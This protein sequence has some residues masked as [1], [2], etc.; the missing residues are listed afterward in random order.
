[1]MVVMELR[2]NTRSG[3]MERSTG[4]HFLAYGHTLG[5]MH[6]KRRSIVWNRNL[7]GLLQRPYP[8][9]RSRLIRAA[10]RRRTRHGRLKVG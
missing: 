9:S 10:L 7:F 1:M 8:S 4:C 5:S 6:S 3:T 2:A